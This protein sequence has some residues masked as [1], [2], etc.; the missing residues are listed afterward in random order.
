ML[1][2]NDDVIEK[3][4]AKSDFQRKIDAFKANDVDLLE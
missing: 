4:K 1:D 3:N 2:D